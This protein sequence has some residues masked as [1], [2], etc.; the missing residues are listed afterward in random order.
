MPENEFI[1]GFPRI[2]DLF[3]EKSGDDFVMASVSALL[4]E[5]VIRTVLRRL[6]WMVVGADHREKTGAAKSELCRMLFALV[7]KPVAEALSTEIWQQ[8]G[9]AEIE[10]IPGIE[11][12]GFNGFAE[13]LVGNGERNPSRHTDDVRAVCRE[14]DQAFFRRNVSL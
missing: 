14:D 7:E 9:F 5:Y 2:T 13:H 6:Q 11:S 12:G 1:Y 4:P 8:H 3:P 10:Y